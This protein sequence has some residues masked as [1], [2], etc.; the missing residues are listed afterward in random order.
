MEQLVRFLGETHLGHQYL[1]LEGLHL[2][3]EG[4]A[5]DLRVLVGQTAGLDVVARILV[6]LH[7]G[8]AHT[9]TSELVELVVLADSG[10]TDAVVDLADL[11]QGVGGVLGHQHD[12]VGV[13]HGHQGAAAGDALA[14]VI[15]P[16][17]HHLLGRNVERLVHD[18][19]PPRIARCSVRKPSKRGARS[20][21]AR[22]SH[23]S[24]V[25]VA[26]TG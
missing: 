1:H 8:V 22:R 9:E 10:E 25:M 2:V 7:V 21:S 3:G 24:D 6:T 15:R 12:A 13:L 19:P 20:E 4:L 5:Q 18:A 23:P 14:G 16:I 11:A 17:L 26:T